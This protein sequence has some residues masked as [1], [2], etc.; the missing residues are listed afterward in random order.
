MR[1]TKIQSTPNFK[2]TQPQTPQASQQPE[3][4]DKLLDKVKNPRDINDTVSVPR[5]IFKAYM[6]L[7]AGTGLGTIAGILPKGLKAIKTPLSIIGSMLGIL[8][9]AYFAKPFLIKQEQGESK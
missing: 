7:M 3:I 1:I 8:S 2:S 4:I 6:C 9:A 5:G